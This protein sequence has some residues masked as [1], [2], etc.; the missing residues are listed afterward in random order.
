VTVELPSG[1]SAIGLLGRDDIG[2]FVIWRVDKTLKVGQE[3]DVR[4]KELHHDVGGVEWTGKAETLDPS[5]ILVPPADLSAFE[6]ISSDQWLTGKVARVADFGIFVTVT[7]PV[8]KAT[9]RGLVHSSQ[10]EHGLVESTNK[11]WKKD[12]AVQVR[13]QS[14]DV[15]SGTMSLTMKS[16]DS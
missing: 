9:A 2:N 6:G 4:I 5:H 13:I 3:Y 8:G 16:I 12:Q 7:A 11:K 14:L 10:I 15:M 1:E